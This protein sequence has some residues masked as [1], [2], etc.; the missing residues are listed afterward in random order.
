M[1]IKKITKIG[2]LSACALILMWLEIPVLPWAPVLKYDPSGIPVLIGGFAL[3]PLSG[4]AIVLI[5]DA[6]FFLFSSSPWKVIGI[7]M[8]FCALAVMTYI[9][10]KIYHKK[11][12]RLNALLGLMTGGIAM[13]AVMYPVNLWIYPLFVKLFMPQAPLLSPTQLFITIIPFNLLK[14]FLNGFIVVLLYK[15]VSFWFK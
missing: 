3:G 13:A 8:D 6:L 12:S 7:P 1:K 5:K 2:V 15:K 9:A 11:K 14:A 4:V 10:G